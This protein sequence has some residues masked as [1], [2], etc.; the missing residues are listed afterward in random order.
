[1]RGIHRWRQYEVVNRSRSLHHMFRRNGWCIYICKKN[2]RVRTLRPVKYAH[3][4]RFV[5]YYD[6]VIKWKHFPRYWPFVRGIHRSR[7]IPRTKASDAE[8]WCLLID[9]RLNKRLSKQWW[10]WWFETPSWSLWRHR[11]VVIIW[12]WSIFPQPSGLL[13]WHWHNYFAS[14]S[15]KP[16][17]LWVYETHESEKKMKMCM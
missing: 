11:N 5:L 14:A 16:S 1:M 8:L 3:G 13:H 4:S 7:W 10:G 6:D 2:I 15:E 17:R 9:L 12:Y